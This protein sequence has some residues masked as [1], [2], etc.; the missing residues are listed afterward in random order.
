MGTSSTPASFIMLIRHAEKPTDQL[1]GV[2]IIGIEDA[3]DLS[4]RGWQRA[5]ALVRFFAPRLPA[6]VV[7]GV[8]TPDFLFAAETSPS[9]PSKRSKNTLVPLADFLHKPICTDFAKDQARELANAILSLSKPVL[10]AWSR[11]Y[12]HLIANALTGDVGQVP[13]G[14]QEDRFD[15]VWVL[16]REASG[17][18]FRQVP[19]L[20]LPRDVA[21]P[22]V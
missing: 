8:M 7:P 11:E 17:W 9:S 15:M 21:Q 14:W 10:V 20:L 19:Q 16:S 12:I 1:R 6:E 4:V 18:T 5:G 3:D 13:Q 2:N 22:I